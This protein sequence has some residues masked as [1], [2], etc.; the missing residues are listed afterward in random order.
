M[1]VR[2]LT[3]P[4]IYI[5]AVDKHTF[6]LEVYQNLVYN[7][8]SSAIQIASELGGLLENVRIYNNVI[9]NNGIVGVMISNC[10]ISQ[11]PMQN[12]TIINNTIFNNGQGNWGGGILD[13]NPQAQNV[14]IRNNICSQNLF[15]QIALESNVPISSI[16]IDHNLID[17][18]RGYQGEVYGRD[19]VVG[20]PGF[21][22]SGN[23]DF[24]L[25][26]SSI[27]IDRASAVNAPS[28][29]FD[30]TLRPQGLGFD[31]GAYEYR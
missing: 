3:R 24:H 17:G 6:N 22:N 31:I 4:G 23:G 18:F 15:F 9:Y 30:G 29:D 5:D 21:V 16:T 11:H 25:V 10:C 12:I 20:N 7:N 27:A 28:D 14:I 13:D 8:S 19:S 1:E 26:A 2:E